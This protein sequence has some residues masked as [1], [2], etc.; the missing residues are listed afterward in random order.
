MAGAPMLLPR[1]AAFW[2]QMTWVNP[3]VWLRVAG[4]IQVPFRSH[5][6]FTLMC[7]P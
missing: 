3:G 6:L 5:L 1:L 4:A 7:I 2:F